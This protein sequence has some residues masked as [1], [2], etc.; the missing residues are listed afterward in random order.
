[1]SINLKSDSHLL[2]QGWPEY[3]I[4]VLLEKEECSPEH[5]ITEMFAQVGGSEQFEDLR[6][7]SLNDR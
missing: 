6:Y 1:M 5:D 7:R 3:K 2:M 4:K